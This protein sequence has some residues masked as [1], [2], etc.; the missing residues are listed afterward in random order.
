MNA[1]TNRLLAGAAIVL[2]LWAH[3]LLAGSYH[4]AGGTGEPNDPY[5]IAT[6][7]QLISIGSNPNLLD[8]HF[9]LLDDIDLDPNLPGGRAFTKPVIAPSDS[10]WFVVGVPFSGTFDGRG[11]SLRNLMFRKS[12]VFYLGFFGDIGQGAV[13]SDLRV[14]NAVLDHA[15]GAYRSVLAGWN[16]GRIVRC[17]VTGRMLDGSFGGMLVGANRGEIIDCWAEGDVTGV[18]CMGGLVGINSYGTILRS[19]A[20]CNVATTY[21]SF[22]VDEPGGGLA[23]ES[24]DGEILSC[25][26]AGNVSGKWGADTMGGLVGISSALIAN[27]YATGNVSATNGKI[28]GGL[29]GNSGG[30]IS[31][32]YATGAV[33]GSMRLGG[34]V[35][36]ASGFI[37]DS[38]AIGR[39]SGGQ[40][41]GLIGSL[42]A[43]WIEE[44]FWDV[45][46]SGRATGN[47]GTGLTTAQM[48]DPATYLAAGWDLAGERENGTADSWFVPEGGGYPLLTADRAALEPHKLDGA[49]TAE[50]PYRIATAE[51]LDAINHYDLTACY[52]LD[53][54]IDLAQS[55]RDKPLVWY[56]DGRLDG[57]KHVIT[58]LT[59]RGGDHLGLFGDLGARASITNLDIR[60]V[61]ITGG[62]YLGALVG[63]SRGRITACRANGT[64]AGRNVLGILTG[65]NEGSIS[66]SYAIG[67]VSSAFTDRSADGHGASSV[68]DDLKPAVGGLT[69]VNVGVIRR[70][71]AAAR[72]AWLTPRENPT[73]YPGGLVGANHEPTR[74]MVAFA[75]GLVDPTGWYLVPPTGAVHEC[76]FLID[77]DGGGPDNGVG[78]ALTDGQMKQQASFPGWDF[79]ATW[80][81][82]AGRDYPRL[83]WESL[84]CEE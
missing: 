48:Q 45:E 38:Y 61:N 83:R 51:D 29:V 35:G 8:K 20:A 62:D 72:V 78:M 79:D 68:S 4:F 18:R 80:T 7:E 22:E 1:K 16:E 30:T 42:G 44:C 71:Y 59:M 12:E 47:G 27:S 58:G 63:R 53:V 43:V 28:L 70:C 57:A 17:G 73:D 15:V 77:T 52:R 14:E 33:S 2:S 50:D 84:P 55:P 23:G 36:I 13:V 6:P 74:S 60:D 9:V 76:Y 56:F 69:G 54:D 26:A 25:W 49:G 37:C 39:I 19:H 82:C 11:H 34:L 67:S 32:C 21:A 31:D 81:I 10:A 64:I 3:S 5:Q 65:W 66:D 24:I 40:D 41:G 46:T 75:K